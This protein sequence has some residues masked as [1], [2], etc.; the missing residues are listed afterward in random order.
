MSS[1]AQRLVV[2][3]DGPGTC[4]LPSDYAPLARLPRGLVLGFIDAG[5]FILMETPHSVLAA[6]YHRNLKGNTAMFDVFLGRPE[7]GRRAAGRARRRLCRILPGRAGAPQLRRGRAGR[8]CGGAR[9]GRG[10]RR[11]SNA[12]RSRARI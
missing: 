3:S 2:I 9:P 11:A 1:G 12:F 7:D 8:T 5:P 6:P 4:R 10:S